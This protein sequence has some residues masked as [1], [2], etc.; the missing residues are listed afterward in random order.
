MKVLVTGATGHVARALLHS[1][2]GDG[3]W[4]LRAA[5]RAAPPLPVANCEYVEVGDLASPA[6]TV[7]GAAAGCDIVVHTAA[8]V[9]VM[10][11]GPSDADLYRRTNVDATLRLAREAAQSGV[12]RFVFL[13]TVKVNG[14]STAVGQAFAE[15]DVPLPQGAYAISKWEAE[16]GLRD[17]CAG[18]GMEY[19]IIRP[20]LVYGPGVR[21]NFQALASAVR[22]GMPLPVG[23]VRNLRSFVAMDNLVD[24]VRVCLQHAGAANQTFLVSDGHDLSTGELVRGMAAALGR[25]ARVPS[26]PVWM[27]RTAGMLTGRQLTIQRLLENLQVDIGK[28]RTQLG[29]N[30]PV[31]VEEGL[32]RALRPAVGP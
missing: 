1:L 2:S 6:A 24:F 19:V 26:V 15:D 13:S 3:G 17:L 14:E 21:A 18:T 29:W 11:E 23:A 8:R 10:D 5:V 32:R 22:R 7:G 31:T 30:P 20:P 28:A 27:L 9:H 12:R 4:Q 16:R 25:P